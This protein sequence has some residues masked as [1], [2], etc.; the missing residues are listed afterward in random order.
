MDHCCHWP[1]LCKTFIS[2]G[3]KITEL[4]TVEQ[5]SAAVFGR[6][7]SDKLSRL[8]HQFYSMAVRKFDGFIKEMRSFS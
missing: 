6:Q 2:L 1:I 4:H 7:L 3:D 5:G 8:S